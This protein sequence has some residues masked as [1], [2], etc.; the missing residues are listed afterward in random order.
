MDEMGER[1]KRAN[2]VNTRCVQQLSH[3][4]SSTMK[5]FWTGEKVMRSMSSIGEY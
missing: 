3:E 5:Q 1:E 4:R 2:G